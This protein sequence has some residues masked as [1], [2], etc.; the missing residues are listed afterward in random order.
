MKL[1]WELYEDIPAL[2]DRVTGDGNDE[3]G[4]TEER[5]VKGSVDAEERAVVVATIA[6]GKDNGKQV[7]GRAFEYDHNWVDQES[8]SGPKSASTSKSTIMDAPL[9]ISSPVFEAPSPWLQA[10]CSSARSMSAVCK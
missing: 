6:V 8:V 5:F 7:D 1:V 9:S 3:D 10:P 2:G 4:I